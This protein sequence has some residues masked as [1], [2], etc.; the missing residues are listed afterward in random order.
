MFNRRCFLQHFV[1]GRY[2]SSKPV[3]I[4]SVVF[5]AALIFA[6]ALLPSS[7][8][9]NTVKNCP[10]E[11]AQNVPIVSGETYSGANCILKTTGDV[12]SFT[13]T[14]AAGDTWSMFTGP[15]PSPASN[16]CLNLFAPGSTGTP[17]FTGCTD[18]SFFGPSTGTTMKLTLAGTYTIVISELANGTTG[19]SLSLERINAPPSDATAL[20][21]ATNVT[22][23]V[24]VPTEQNAY[25]FF[26]ATTGVY[27]IA[28][29]YTS[30]A[31]NVC[32]NVYQSGASVS[33]TPS[34]PQC[35]NVSFGGGA[36]AAN[37][38][39]T[40]NG[41]FVIVVYAATNDSTVN[42]NLEVTCFLGTCPVPPPKTTCSLKDVL[43]YNATTATLTMHFTLGT[44]VAAT[45]NA[46]LTAQNTMQ[47][48]WS[49]S[50]PITEPAVT[51]TKTQALAKSGKVGVLSTLTTP[52]KGI[53][54]SSWVMINTGTP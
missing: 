53:T 25:T 31:D 34:V 33:A 24:G 51:I 13:F 10:V 45:W 6:T 54:C 11:P 52:T 26:G 35:T 30:G 43:S 27:R 42:Y 15:E 1:P 2:Q 9:A 23:T 8:W 49:L 41:T 3:A 39:P 16:I 47:Q 17:I 7:L 32:F 37:V 20:T 29:S 18:I 40:T 50:E 22:G 28:A 46:W 14:A 38:T 48:L 21:L 36:I 12:D 5:L 19:Y 4:R 44:P